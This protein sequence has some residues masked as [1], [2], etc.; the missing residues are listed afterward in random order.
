MG[1]EFKN[2]A[3][4]RINYLFDLIKKTDDFDLPAI[5]AIEKIRKT[6]NIRLDKNQKEVYCKFCLTKYKNAKIRFKKI[7]KNGNKY[8]QKTIYCN[9]CKNKKTLLLRE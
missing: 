8:L 5:N 4:E 3:I 6:F 9:N 1:K 2:I 7:K